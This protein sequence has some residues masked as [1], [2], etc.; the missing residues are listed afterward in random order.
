MKR[1]KSNIRLFDG[2]DNGQRTCAICLGD[3]ED[4]D[5]ICW[6]NN[7]DC[8]HHFHSTCGVAWLARHS[9]CPICRAD[10]L[11]EPEILQ[12]ASEEKGAV[13]DLPIHLDLGNLDEELQNR[14]DDTPNDEAS[15]DE[16][17]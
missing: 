5:Q 15:P 3:Y 4:G 16:N 1:L 13:I 14:A 8:T 2:D 6:S 7:Q 11:V 17:V 9:Q 10:Y 12:E